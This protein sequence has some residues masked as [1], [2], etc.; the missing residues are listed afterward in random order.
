[1]GMGQLPIVKA[2]PLNKGSTSLLATP[3][4]IP[5]IGNSA[6][7]GVVVSERNTCTHLTK[8][9]DLSKISSKI[10][11]VESVRC[12][13]CREDAVDRRSGFVSSS[14]PSTSNLPSESSNYLQR[15]EFHGFELPGSNLG[16]MNFGSILGGN[17]QQLPGLELVLSQD[18][19]IGVLNPQALSQ[20]YQQMGQSRGVA[21]PMHQQQQQQQQPP[22][23]DDSQGLGQ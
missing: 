20:F 23:K 9:V 5:I 2:S 4:K 22:A 14:S 6:G 10:G 18:G 8:G 13:D 12:E 7:A 11:S 17:T 19:H 3:A 16:P 15:I 21:G 1:M